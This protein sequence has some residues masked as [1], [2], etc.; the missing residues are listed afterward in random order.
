MNI[1]QFLIFI[2]LVVATASCSSK[3]NKSVYIPTTYHSYS[4][5]PYEDDFVKIENTSTDFRQIRGEEDSSTDSVR[6]FLKKTNTLIKIRKIKKGYSDSFKDNYEFH[7]SNTQTNYNQSV[8][9]KD[10]GKFMT[11]VPTRGIVCWNGDQNGGIGNLKFEEKKGEVFHRTRSPRVQVF[12]SHNGHQLR[13]DKT[14]LVDISHDKRLYEGS[15]HVYDKDESKKVANY[16]SLFDFKQASNQINPDFII[17]SAKNVQLARVQNDGLLEVITLDKNLSEKSVQKNI[18]YASQMPD[19]PMSSDYYS[20]PYRHGLDD[21]NYEII[22]R[23][24]IANN[25][26]Q[27]SY[28]LLK[29][30]PTQKNWFV[31]LDVD[32]EESLPSNAVGMIPLLVEEEMFRSDK[33]KE[34]FQAVHGWIIAYLNSNNKISYGW[35]SPE[36]SW[37][38]GPVWKDVYLHERTCISK[39]DFQNKNLNKTNVG[40]FM[41]QYLR[42]AFSSINQYSKPVQ[43]MR[44]VHGPF[45]VAQNLDET[46]QVYTQQAYL[47]DS[48]QTNLATYNRPNNFN[49]AFLKAKSDKEAILQ[50]EHWLTSYQNQIKQRMEQ[51]FSVLAKHYTTIAQRN[52][53]ERLK[54]KMAKYEA[55]Q[56]ERDRRRMEAQAREDQIRA[57][58]RSY[59]RAKAISAIESGSFTNRLRNM[60]SAGS[61]SRTINSLKSMSNHLRK[62]QGKAYQSR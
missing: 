49:N 9:A 41:L 1:I 60:S 26:N 52:R 3:T 2:M 46:W 23:N 22:G 18:F 51:R 34:T 45:I 15:A 7:V 17:S 47:F 28:S 8:S 53:D 10:C 58:Q 62:A 56:R 19:E 33:K 32:G 27:M 35:G 24:L 12:R 25:P 40:C 30:H 16:S 48:M 36:L 59:N 44:F 37:V 43:E 29:V 11:Y 6:L 14:L 5:T 39:N 57:A 21:I 42:Y 61:S 50:A 31:F 55:E 38:S 54:E 4:V 20:Y 13:S